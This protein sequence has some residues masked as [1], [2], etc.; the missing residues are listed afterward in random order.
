MKNS[1]VIVSLKNTEQEDIQRLQK[2]RLQKLFSSY[3]AG[4]YNRHGIQNNRQNGNNRY[5][6]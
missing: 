4:G 1:I 6:E 5:N 2:G 3:R